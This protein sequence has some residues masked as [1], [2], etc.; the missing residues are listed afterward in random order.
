MFCRRIREKYET[1]LD[2]LERSER[3]AMEKYNQMKAELLEAQGERERLK[4]LNR[5]KEQEVDDIKRVSLRLKLNTPV[6][7]ACQIYSTWIWDVKCCLPAIKL[8]LY[9]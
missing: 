9:F 8:H 3:S 4:V 2:E 6:I 5:Q 7:V 1:E